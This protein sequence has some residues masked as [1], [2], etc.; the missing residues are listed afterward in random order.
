MRPISRGHFAAELTTPIY[1]FEGGQFV[2]E[3][4]K[5]IKKRLGRSPDLADALALTFMLPELP[6]N[7]DLPLGHPNQTFVAAT[8]IPDWDPIAEERIA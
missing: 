8:R 5:L 1:W 7:P 4:K 2:M 6:T 3:D